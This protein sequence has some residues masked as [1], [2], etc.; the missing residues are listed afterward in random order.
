MGSPFRQVTPPSSNDESPSHV[1]PAF[2]LH[3]ITSNPRTTKAHQ[4]FFHQTPAQST[5]S[6][7]L[8]MNPSATSLP[9]RL[10][11]DVVS[12]ASPPDTSSGDDSSSHMDGLHGEQQPSAVLFDVDNNDMLDYEFPLNANTSMPPVSDESSPEGLL[13]ASNNLRYLPQPTFSTNPQPSTKFASADGS[14]EPTASSPFMTF[15]HPMSSPQTRFE[16]AIMISDNTG[17]DGDSPG[18]G[19]QMH[20]LRV[21]SR[22]PS[23]EQKTVC[24]ED[25]MMD[26]DIFVPSTT[27][28]QQPAPPNGTASFEP[29]EQHS[30]PRQ[31][32]ASNHAT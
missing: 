9:A 28:E 22:L 23:P 30:Q 3:G 10:G 19:S 15:E 29:V 21:N 32:V 18:L 7:S 12:P 20:G 31:P 27:S 1:S 26:R 14:P 11:H 25:V 16:S 24:P 8:F 4:H 5:S 17:P 13:L 6:P 2:P